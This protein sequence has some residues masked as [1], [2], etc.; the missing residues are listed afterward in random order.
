MHM[1]RRDQHPEGAGEVTDSPELDIAE[2]TEITVPDAVMTE[3]VAISGSWELRRDVLKELFEESLGEMKRL[4]ILAEEKAV[5]GDVDQA[6]VIAEIA[7]R[8]RNVVY[9]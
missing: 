5:E 9:I 7:D 2:A 3:M 4:L 1:P 8:W 6:R